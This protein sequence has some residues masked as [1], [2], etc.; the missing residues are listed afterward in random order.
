MLSIYDTALEPSTDL[1]MFVM[2][3]KFDHDWQ[4]LLMLY[5]A[6]VNMA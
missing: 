1:V 6:H 3:G 4:S 2:R 5:G